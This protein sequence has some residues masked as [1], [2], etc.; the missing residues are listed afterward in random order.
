MRQNGSDQPAPAK[1]PPTAGEVTRL[2]RDVTEGKLESF[3]PLVALVYTDLRR[4]AG[5]MMRRER[6]SHTLQTTD[7]VHEAYLR[8]VTQ[9][10]A[11]WQN[12]GHFLAIASQAMRRILVE[13]AR[14]RLT[15]KRGGRV[16]QVP[17]DE[18]GMALPISDKQCNEVVALDDALERLEQLEP[19]QSKIIELRFFGGLTEEEIARVLGVSDRTVKRDWRVARAWLNRALEAGP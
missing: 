10:E 13:H 17:L 12:K 19:R 5:A 3:E 2:L 8:L 18:E 1:L 9:R 11:N 14:K 6:P 7:L 4:V 16:E 15:L